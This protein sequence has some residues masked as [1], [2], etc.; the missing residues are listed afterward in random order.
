M[1]MVHLQTYSKKLSPFLSLF[2]PKIFEFDQTPIESSKLSNI[3][4]NDDFLQV[5]HQTDTTYKV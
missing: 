2:R 4:D 3:I 5:K 1:L